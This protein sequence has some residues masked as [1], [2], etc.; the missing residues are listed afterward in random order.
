MKTILITGT[1]SGLGRA[2]VELFAA[3]G[4]NVI[5]T[6]R[7]PEKETELNILEG[8]FVTRLDVL[9]QDSIAEAI[10]AGIERFGKIDALVN[11]A[12]YGQNGV[13]ESIS[14]EQIIKQFET[15]VIGVMDVTRG[16]IPHFRANG[17][18][19]LI[20]ISSCGGLIGIPNISIYSS[21]KFAIE[22]FSESISYEL[23]SQNITVKLVEPGGFD[24][25][26]AATTE[27]NKPALPLPH[28]Y[29]DFLEDVNRFF[30]WLSTDK[31]ISMEDV[32]KKIYEAATD[33]KTQLRYV[34][35]GVVEPLVEA[36]QT[37]GNQEFVDMMRVRLNQ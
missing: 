37:M 34:I 29:D 14:R 4:W 32:A 11:N 30:L 1:S 21:S 2:A 28:A 20:N 15:N 31:G 19:T 8:V 33:G 27:H 3:S 10:Q 7:S 18:G 24:S 26:Y 22:G 9:D 5:A 35:P 13:F 12:G 17:G 16:I 6:M 25:N 23:A 36:R